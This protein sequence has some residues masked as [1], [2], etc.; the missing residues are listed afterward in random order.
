MADQ[1]IIGRHPV[2]EALRA[3]RPLNRIFLQR[4]A[5][6]DILQEILQLAKERQVPVKQVPAEKLRRM[7]R[8]THQGCIAL[9]SP[10]VYLELQQVI[11]YVVEKGETPL[12][13]L[14]EGVTDVRNLGAIA[15][16]AHCFGAQALILPGKD[17]APINEQAIK[18]SAGALEQLMVA[19][20]THTR[21]AIQELHLNGIQVIASSVKEGCLPRQVDWTQP[22]ALLVGAEDQGLSDAEL[23]LADRVVTIPIQAGFD[24][25]NVSVAAGILLYEAAMQ[26]NQLFSSSK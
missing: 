11:S 4:H 7:T 14:V 19:R 24:S 26:R 17:T 25:L 23:K 18:A 13:I 5:S 10:V 6:G 9:A 16:S 2:L 1:L 12:F 20:I 22:V 21:A 15:R 3:G 8:A